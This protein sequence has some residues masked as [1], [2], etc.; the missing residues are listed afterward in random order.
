MLVLSDHPATLAVAR[1]GQVVLYQRFFERSSASWRYRAVARQDSQTGAWLDHTGFRK[2]HPKRAEQALDQLR[3]LGEEP[4]HLSLTKM[5][6]LSA[7]PESETAELMALY[8]DFYRFFQVNALLVR[9]A[10]AEP[11]DRP[12]RLAKLLPPLNLALA[13]DLL[14]AQARMHNEWVPAIA[15]QIHA[16]DFK[17]DPYNL[18]AGTARA[19]SDLAL[20]AGD[21]EGAVAHLR[22]SQ[23][24]RPTP[25]KGERL[26][27]LAGSPGKQA[28]RDPNGQ[29]DL[30]K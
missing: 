9:Q 8:A 7:S 5:P 18:G 3:A 10:L 24:L 1:D 14:E 23:T 6:D 17:D 4:A 12:L 25:A 28:Q 2:R 20:R 27:M 29:I 21:K 11:L 19:L 15:E 22:L 13:L 26:D 16:P 30:T